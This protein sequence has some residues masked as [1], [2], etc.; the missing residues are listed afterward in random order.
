MKL[1]QG[2]NPAGGQAPSLAL[3]YRLLQ[4]GCVCLVGEDPCHPSLALPPPVLLSKFLTSSPWSTHG[5]GQGQIPQ[6]C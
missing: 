4:L 1:S 3:Q 5:Q 6:R 2:Q